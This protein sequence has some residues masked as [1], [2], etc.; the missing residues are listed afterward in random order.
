MPH[1]QLLTL[2]LT[3]RKILSP[4][5][6]LALPFQFQELSGPKHM[7]PPDSPPIAYFHLFFTDVI[8][9]LMMTESNRYMQQV[10][11]SKAGNVPTLLKNWTSIAMHEM[12][13]FLACI[14]NVGII[15]KPATASFWSTVCSQAVQWF[16]KMFTKHSFSHLLCF[17]H[18]VN[19]QGLPVP[20]EP[21]YDPCA[22]YQPLVYHANRVFRHH[23]TPH[24]EINV[25]EAW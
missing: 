2:F 16:G 23:Y 7:L 21:G 4:E 18:L 5:Q 22:R 1:H 24:Q 19:N 13:G 14:L 10:I 12:K 11:S 17:F 25:S 15:K 8:L 20:G 9:T 3:D 6:P